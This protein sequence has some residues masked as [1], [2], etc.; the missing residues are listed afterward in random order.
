VIASGS[1]SNGSTAAGVY[2]RNVAAKDSS[3]ADAEQAPVVFTM[4]AP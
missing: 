3:K 1:L 2:F 4:S